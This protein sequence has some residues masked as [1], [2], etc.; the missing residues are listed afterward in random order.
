MWTQSA[1]ITWCIITF[2]REK[3]FDM[4]M[5]CVKCKEKNRHIATLCRCSQIG[6]AS[7]VLQVL[8][9][10]L[11]LGLFKWPDLI[12]LGSIIYLGQSILSHII[13]LC[14]HWAGPE[15][16]SHS[17]ATAYSIECCHYLSFNLRVYSTSACR[18][19]LVHLKRK[20]IFYKYFLT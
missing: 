3:V 1:L 7:F 5:M 10:S 12:I 16:C 14:S 19:Q 9:F 20:I 18:A 8:Q 11:C 15:I 6:G 17:T 2:V 4:Q 13:H